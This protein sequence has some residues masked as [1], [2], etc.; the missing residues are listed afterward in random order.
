M[1]KTSEC[2][3]AVTQYALTGMLGLAHSMIS[4]QCRRLLQA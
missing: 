4:E 2:T 1:P 3:F